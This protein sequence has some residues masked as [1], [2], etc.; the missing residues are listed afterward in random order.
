MCTCQAENSISW[1]V[2]TE[3]LFFV[4]APVKLKCMRL[5]V[6]IPKF[7]RYM[8][9]TTVHHLHHSQLHFNCSARVV[10]H[11]GQWHGVSLDIK[12]EVPVQMF[13]NIVPHGITDI[14]GSGSLITHP[15]ALMTSLCR[16]QI[17]RLL[18]IQLVAAETRYAEIVGCSGGWVN[19]NQTNERRNGSSAWGPYATPHCSHSL[20]SL[21]CLRI[22]VEHS[23]VGIIL[24]FYSIAFI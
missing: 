7:M 20:F 6:H 23:S 10:Q 9:T 21:M 3:F 11:Q 8:I 5:N 18:W 13:Y 14:R 2:N 4:Y 22:K 19:A 16:S 15:E 12:G 24:H 1:D 17:S